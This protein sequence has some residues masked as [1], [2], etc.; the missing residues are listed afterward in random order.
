M[1]R[2][3]SRSIG[4][5]A[6]GLL[7]VATVAACGDDDDATDATSAGAETAA[8]TSPP[9]AATGTT[10][11]PD[12]S[13]A[14]SATDAAPATSAAPA[15]G[16]PIL[17][18]LANDEG[19]AV[20]FPEYR[21]GAEA[22][23]AL[24]NADGGVNGAPIELITCIAD[25]SPE[26]S[27]NCA[28]RFVD[29]SAVA[30]VAGLEVGADAALPVLESAGIPYV[31]PTAWGPGQYTDANAFILHTAGGAFQAGSIA[32]L[33]EAGATKIANFHYDIPTSTATEPLYDSIAEEVGVELFHVGVPIQGADW[34]A[35]VATAVANG[36]DALIGYFNE[37]DC[38]NLVR[39][40]RAAGFDGP[41]AP[42]SCSDYVTELG[43]DAV[44]TITVADRYPADLR[45]DAPPEA[46]VQ[47][48][49]YVAA[50]DEA[51]Y[52]DK[53]GGLARN[54]FSTV[55]ELAEIM[56]TI[57]G[58]VTAESLTVAL[59]GLTDF[60]GFMGPDI[61]CTEPFG[62]IPRACSAEV[63]VISVLDGPTRA[64]EGGFVDMSR[65][66]D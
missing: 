45:D 8:P 24:I 59:T 7:L 35:S 26:A 62:A 36:A 30:Y 13:S 43:D 60:P 63:I 38:T 58:E 22:A 57:D 46:Q 11:A 15:T 1:R 20:N 65:F 2:R 12:D 66:G 14:S 39:G 5:A 41:I 25:G 53:A 61:N 47:I 4:R 23:V 51:G 52:G 40:A 56:K 16:E 37:I 28:N 19:A 32:A 3:T 21:E 42:G 55:Y 34:N 64:I 31:S 6:A 49:A 29:A 50:M 17:V 48:D 18:G 54:S 44:G 10:D 33:A 9:A 27:V